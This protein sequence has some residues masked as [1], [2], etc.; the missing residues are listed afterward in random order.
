VK[1]KETG[2]GILK[3]Q[4]PQVYFRI[5][6][7]DKKG[8]VRYSVSRKIDDFL[9]LFAVLK[10]ALPELPV[11]SLPPVADLKNWQPS[12]MARVRGNLNY[13]VQSL[14]SREELMKHPCVKVFLSAEEDDA[15]AQAHAAASLVKVTRKTHVFGDR[16]EARDFFSCVVPSAPFRHLPLLPRSFSNVHR[17]CCSLACQ[18]STYLHDAA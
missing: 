9:W 17:P 18:V 1:V 5:E 14:C 13:F 7:T 11:P 2:L 6:T 3:T 8:D 15:A 4:R 16:K 12:V 10:P